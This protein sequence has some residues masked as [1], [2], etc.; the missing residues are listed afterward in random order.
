MVRG[1]DGKRGKGR[2]KTNGEERVPCLALVWSP[3]G[4]FSDAPGPKR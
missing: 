3:H 1:R 4:D 2:E